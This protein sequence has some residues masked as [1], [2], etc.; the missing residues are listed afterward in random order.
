MYCIAKIVHN[1]I[2]NY[3]NPLSAELIVCS[4]VCEYCRNYST[5]LLF[6]L[7][8]IVWRSEASHQARENP[9]N[10]PP[11]LW[12]K[13][14]FKASGWGGLWVNQRFV[15]SI[16]TYKPR[17]IREGHLTLTE[18][19]LSAGDCIFQIIIRRLSPYEPN[20]LPPWTICQQYHMR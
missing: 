12:W 18:V 19:G 13:V 7:G 20:G 3:N 17:R 4:V 6:W 14:F 11:L 10:H 15:L 5:C 9:V 16:F 2:C 1:N 8:V